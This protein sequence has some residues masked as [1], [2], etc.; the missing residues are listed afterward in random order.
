MGLFQ[1]KAEK[2]YLG[3]AVTCAV[4][5]TKYY[6]LKSSM[7]PS[8]LIGKYRPASV[9]VCMRCGRAYCMDSAGFGGS[10]AMQMQMSGGCTCNPGGHID[11]MT[12]RYVK[13]L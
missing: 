1:S 7:L 12:D 5:G 9:G 10:C 8:E 3:E 2:Q 11:L 6:K 4:C 13:K